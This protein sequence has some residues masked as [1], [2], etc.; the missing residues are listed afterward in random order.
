MKDNFSSQSDKY[1]RFRP[2]YPDALYH[3]LLSIVPAR[4][5]AWDCGTG[6]GQVAQVLAASFKKVFATDISRQ[7]IE[8]AF[9]HERIGYS[10]QPAENTSFPDD[11]FDLITVAQAIHWFDFDAFYR[12]V[13]RTIRNKGVLAVIGY[14]LFRLSPALDTIIAA[15]YRDVVGPYWD[16]ERKYID[17]NYRT[18]PFPFD[19]IETPVFENVFEWTFEHL[20]GYL[21]TWSAVKHYKK[22]TSKDPVDLIHDELK[23]A[24]GERET[25][26]GSFP[27]LL[28]VARIEK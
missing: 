25:C 23:K 14:G 19:E 15:F 26:T 24:W 2:T 22:A 16:K 4:D 21:G 13:I 17:D 7:Q 1:A 11:S 6:N 9:R 20:I 5:N 10:V 18:I 3:Y 28:R 27:I 8:N 12:E